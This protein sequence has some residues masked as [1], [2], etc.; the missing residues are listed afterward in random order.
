ML[1]MTSIIQQP[2]YTW[3][4]FKKNCPT[5]TVNPIEYWLSEQQSVFSG[6]SEIS[7][8]ALSFLVDSFHEI[9]KPVKYF[10]HFAPEYQPER[11]KG[12]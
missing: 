12:L 3:G 8:T 10:A 5:L 2:M 4:N 7:V 11:L 1:M 6:F 9:F